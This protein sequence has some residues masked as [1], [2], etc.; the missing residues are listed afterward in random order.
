MVVKDLRKWG[1]TVAFTTRLGGVSEGPYGELNLAYHV[2]DEAERVAVNRELLCKALSL[3]LDRLT[4]AE[5]VHGSAI[6]EVDEKLAGRGADSKCAIPGADGLITGLAGI[7]LAILTADCVP[8]VLVDP[9]NG[10][11]GVV[12][13]GWRGTIAGIAEVAVERL[14]R[15]GADPD[16]L[17]AYIG[18]SIGPCCYE[19]SEELA[20]TFERKFGRE[21]RPAKRRVDLKTANE[22][23]LERAG[24]Q[25]EAIIDAGICTSCRGDLF[26]SYRA[27]RRITGRQA[28]I[29][30]I[31]ANR[32]VAG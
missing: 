31:N 12:H 1:A 6:A 22:I 32:S 7:P 13:A 10:K 8:V 25:P 4:C 5:Q 9:I 26:F 28:A 3:R 18:P 11:V 15:A 14:V 20:A 23:S 2:G 27:H 16:N 17:L 24:L 30:S 21:A 29:A 19:V